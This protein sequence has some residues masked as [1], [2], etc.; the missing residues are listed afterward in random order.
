[1]RNLS[2]YFIF[3][4]ATML[5]SCTDAHNNNYLKGEK[6]EKTSFP[7]E[8]KAEVFH[9]N[10][11]DSLLLGVTNI[12]LFKNTILLDHNHKQPELI[13]FINNEGD[14]ETLFM[15]GNGPNE[16]IYLSTSKNFTTDSNN[17]VWIYMF[18]KNKNEY[19][20]LNLTKR[21]NDGILERVDLKAPKEAR[22]YFIPEVI[23]ANQ[24]VFQ[25]YDNID[26]IHYLVIFDHNK[27]ETIKKI[28]L[29]NEKYTYPFNFTAFSFGLN[30][31]LKRYSIAPYSMDQI[32]V[33]DLE[34]EQTKI[35]SQNKKLVDWNTLKNSPDFPPKYYGDNT[36]LG[37]YFAV[38]KYDENCDIE[39][40][41]WDCNP[42]LKIKTDLNIISINYVESLKALYIFTQ[43]EKL[44][45]MNLEELIDL[46]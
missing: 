14:I 1:M 12:E 13:S 41:D 20:K 44:Y 7:K 31:E 42:I 34:K 25:L 45:L 46:K 38:C 39:I 36:N 21:V 16:F 29:S 17:N 40:Y 9:L 18:D 30:P 23:D 37:D 33:I 3:V 28:A 5:I 27:G 8:C 6:I 24:S 32:G 35:F 15:S 10:Q 11:F 22:E 43:D 2:L 19:F 26:Q 4:L